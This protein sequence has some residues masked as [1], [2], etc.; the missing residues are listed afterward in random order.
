MGSVSVR[1]TACVDAPSRKT[2]MASASDAMPAAVA[3]VAT[4]PNP[5]A[6]AAEGVPNSGAPDAAT[7][8]YAWYF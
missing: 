6:E 5:S 8:T 7:C 3:E 4:A 2:P 1:P